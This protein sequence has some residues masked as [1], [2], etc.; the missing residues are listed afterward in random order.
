ME[1]DRADE[2]R[3]ELNWLLEKQAQVLE[4]RSLGVATDAEVLE[5]EL[6]QEVVHEICSQLA[7]STQT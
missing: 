7:R 4:S 1:S 2:L 3:T 5:Y 6:R